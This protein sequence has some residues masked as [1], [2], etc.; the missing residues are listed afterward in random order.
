MDNF[1]K[2]KLESL[3]WV[4]AIDRVEVADVYYSF[5]YSLTAEYKAKHINWSL[6]F[7]TE[8]MCY[9]RTEKFSICTTKANVHI[10]PVGSTNLYRIFLTFSEENNS[11]ENK[12]VVSSDD[13][14]ELDSD[15]AI[16]E[17]QLIYLCNAPCVGKNDDSILTFFKKHTEWIC[18]DSFKNV[19]ELVFYHDFAFLLI[20]PRDWLLRCGHEQ[21]VIKSII[22]SNV[23]LDKAK[24]TIEKNIGE[25][26]FLN[27]N[28]CFKCQLCQAIINEQ[29]ITGKEGNLVMFNYT[30]TQAFLYY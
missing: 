16:E 25:K 1:M 5:Y 15:N 17:T 11:E 23:S 18:I 8:G 22:L 24:F 29:T 10:T 14:E 12:Y 21:T 26:R 6:V 3:I 27:G 2:S 19:Y 4:R 7:I 28:S 13:E 20:N 9:L 30:L